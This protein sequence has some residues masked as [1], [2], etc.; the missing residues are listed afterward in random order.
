MHENATPRSNCVPMWLAEA[1][2]SIE[3]KEQVE[4]I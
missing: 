3:K 2:K 4:S 1:S